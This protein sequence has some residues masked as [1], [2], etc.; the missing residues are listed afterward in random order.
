[1]PGGNVSQG[2]LDGNQLVRSALKGF[3]SSG[4]SIVSRAPEGGREEAVPGKD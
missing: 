3:D 1:M 4:S 2:V